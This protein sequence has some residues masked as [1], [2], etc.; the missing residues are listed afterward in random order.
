ML[1]SPSL[2]SRIPTRLWRS[3]SCP[4][5]T[6]RPHA[7]AAAA[8]SRRVCCAPAHRIRTQAHAWGPV[9]SSTR[10]APL[11][12]HPPLIL[13]HQIH[14]HT[15][16]YARVFQAFD[17]G[18]ENVLISWNIPSVIRRNFTWR[19]RNKR[20]LGEGDKGTHVDEKGLSSHSMLGC[21]RVN[22]SRCAETVCT[23]SKRMC[24]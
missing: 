12:R 10:S 13:A 5:L 8:L 21:F 18:C 15:G 11:R 2:V 23:S 14:E 24:R 7:A 6:S 19:D 22:S 20:A 17:R 1:T 4:A 9:Y 3:K 16:T